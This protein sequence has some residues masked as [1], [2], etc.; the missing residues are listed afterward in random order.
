[1]S[2]TYA[3]FKS[4]N[5]TPPTKIT[6]AEYDRD[7]HH[8]KIYDAFDNPLI[9]KQGEVYQHHFARKSGEYD[10]W[11]HREMTPWHRKWQALSQRE[12]LECR[13]ERDGILHIADILTPAG[14]VIE[15]QHSFINLENTQAREAFYGNMIWLIDLTENQP[16]RVVNFNQQYGLYHASSYKKHFSKP[17]FF[18]V[19]THV[20]KIL[21]QS[22][23]DHHFFGEIVSYSDFVDE[24]FGDA[25]IDVR[26]DWVKV[27]LPDNDVH[28][29]P[30]LRYQIENWRLILRMLNRPVFGQ[31]K[32]SSWVLFADLNDDEI[33]SYDRVTKL[34]VKIEKLKAESVKLENAKY[35]VQ[36]ILI[37]Q[38]GG[39]RY[40]ELNWKRSRVRWTPSQLVRPKPTKN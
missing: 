38:E 17:T 32:H 28:I 39:T 37:R 18:D 29:A 26:P 21:W 23:S 24:Y 27:P 9:A 11:A 40:I 3:V 30:E 5:I 13:I 14:L 4:D 22:M 7:L 15:V 34:E 12:Y 20:V 35:E 8:E 25:V 33:P 6:I 2:I 1:M 36:L 16:R 31:R 19:G 10:K